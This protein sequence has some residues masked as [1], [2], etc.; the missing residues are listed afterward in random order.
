MLGLDGC[1]RRGG[2]TVVVKRGSGVGF[3]AG[4]LRE[5]RGRAVGVAK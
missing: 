3:Y 1:G 4:F 5:N 2:K